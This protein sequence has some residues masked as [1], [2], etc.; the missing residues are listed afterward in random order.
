M[1]P[2]LF[3]GSIVPN[4]YLEKSKPV[5]SE[6]ALINFRAQGPGTGARGRIL[7]TCLTGVTQVALEV[8]ENLSDHDSLKDLIKRAGLEFKRVT[9][10]FNL[11]TRTYFYVAN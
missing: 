7:W 2:P 9:P 11:A 1:I 3:Q 5:S 8:R 6:K 4:P 10:L